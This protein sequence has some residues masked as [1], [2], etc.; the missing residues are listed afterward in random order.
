[1]KNF[2]TLIAAAMVAVAANA[3]LWKVTA[4]ELTDG[5]TIV[6]NSFADIKVAN[7][8]V[9]PKHHENESGEENSQE[10]AGESFAYDFNLRVTDA[11]SATSPTGTA[12][13]D[14][15]AVVVEAKKNVDVALYYKVGATKSLDCYDQTKNEAVGLQ[16]DADNPGDEYLFCKGVAQLQAG[17]TYTF[18]S[19][20][21]TTN[22][23]GIETAEGTYVAPSNNFYANT[24]ASTVDGFSTMTYGDGAM[25][26]LVGNAS[27]AFSNGSSITI[28]GKKYTSTKVSNGAQNKFIAPEGKFITKVTIYSYV[29]KDAATNRD[30]FWKE[31]AG[32]NYSLDGAE[33]T[34]QTTI[35]QCY[36]GATPDAYE[37]TINAKEFTFTNTGEQACFVLD[38]TYGN[39]SAVKAAKSE[40][41]AAKAAAKMMKGGKVVIVTE[42]GTVDA[43]GAAVK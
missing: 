2:F 43:A 22:V 39:P 19:R 6:S 23:F 35:M 41:K 8:T 13:G 32:T 10:I 33:G 34:T 29:N 25:I 27:K 11:P 3:Q 12:Y 4:D 42:N 21:G 38:V 20:G 40:A 37:Y 24:A 9:T 30:C 36:K 5:A 28:D 16:Q 14:A 31:V 7:A 26:Q 18:W 1:M 15:V 17:H